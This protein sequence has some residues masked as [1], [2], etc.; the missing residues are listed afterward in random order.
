MLIVNVASKCGLTK[1]NYKQLAEISDKY[2]E[3]GLRVLLFPCNQ[4]GGQEP[5]TSE[6]IC[7]F[8]AGYGKK[9]TIFEKINVNGDDAHP[10]YKFLKKKLSGFLVDAIKWNFTK[11]HNG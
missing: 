7:E 2:T 10:L 3:Q 11:V 4:F 8:I 9:F 1:D 6:Q 5:G